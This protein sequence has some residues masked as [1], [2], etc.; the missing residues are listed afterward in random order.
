MVALDVETVSLKDRT[1]VGLAIATSPTEATYFPYYPNGSP[2]LKHVWSSATTIIMHNSLFDLGVLWD[3]GVKPTNIEDT[4]VMARLLNLSSR[5]SELY[6]WADGTQTQNI[7]TIMKEHKVKKVS[8]LPD[9]VVAQK[10]CED[11]RATYALYMNLKDKVDQEYYRKEMELQEALGKLL[12]KYEREVQD[13]RDYFEEEYGA[14]IGSNQQVGYILAT[15][16]NVLPPTPSGKWLSVKE[17]VLKKVD[18]P[19]AG[20][21]LSFRGSNKL[22]TTYLRPYNKKERAYAEFYPDTITGR[23]SSKNRNLQNIPPG[24]RHIFIPDS[25]IW[26][27]FDYSQVEMRILAHYTEDEKMARTFSSGGDIHRA[28]AN[29]LG[30]PRRRAKN[31]NFAMIYGATVSTVAEMA[32]VGMK[33]AGELL[34]G[35]FLAYPQAAAWIRATQEQGVRDGYITTM[36]GRAINLPLEWRE[37]AVRRKAVNY[38]IQGSAAEIHKEA[39]RRCAD[40][41]L[42]ALLHDEA[43]LD[44]DYVAELQKRE[45]EHIFPVYTPIDIKTGKNWRDLHEVS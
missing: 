36:G 10:C 18:D 34:R 35:F 4:I 33:E 41:D 24:I 7:K 42:A 27:D 20:M 37:E 23:L 8:D 9:E 15:R 16:G 13:Y 39:T 38:I 29:A 1:L 28:T 31:V 32:E 30:I 6:F 22:L 43:L 3:Y 44:G 12:R 45:L 2:F 26:T 40:M 5:L 17:K 21:I 25:G 14:N 11:A 19:L